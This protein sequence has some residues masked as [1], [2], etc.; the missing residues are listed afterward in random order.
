MY[1]F[2]ILCTLWCTPLL[3]A[4]ESHENL[5]HATAHFGASFAINQTLYTVNRQ[6]LQMDKPNA[7]IFSVF[8]TLAIGF[9]YKY[10]EV[11]STPLGTDVTQDMARAM[12]WNVAGVLGSS[13][14]IE[15][16]SW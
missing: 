8:T 15:L 12:I 7:L 2:I 3:L 13:F 11:M 1:K 10:M 16:G 6:I 5:V 9:T 4:D 14:V